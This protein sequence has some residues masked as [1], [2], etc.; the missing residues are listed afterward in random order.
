M[1]GHQKLLLC[2]VTRLNLTVT[3]QRL[4]D[5]NCDVINRD[6]LWINPFTWY[7]QDKIRK[8]STLQITCG[9]NEVVELSDTFSMF[10]V[11]LIHGTC[12]QMVVTFV[13]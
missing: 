9:Q 7:K 10:S 2:D 6:Y 11:F 5:I 8:Q 13:I 3:S 12:S 4:I 1:C